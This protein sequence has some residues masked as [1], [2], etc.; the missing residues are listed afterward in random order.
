MQTDDIN[1][2]TGLTYL[3]CYHFAI[4]SENGKALSGL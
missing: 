4:F 3:C 1:L 2:R